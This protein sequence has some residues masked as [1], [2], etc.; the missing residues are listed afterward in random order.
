MKP[1]H[2]FLILCLLLF[3]Y[4]GYGQVKIGDPTGA[5]DP[6]AIL[7]LKDT[8]RG[9][10]LPR[11]TQ[12][13]M[14]AIPAPPDG[15]LIYNTSSN[16]IF[17]YSQPSLQWKPIMAD[18][19]EW[20]FDLSSAKLYLRRALNNEDSFYYNTSSRKFMF[21][22]TRIY[23]TSLGGS[24]NLDE[25]NSDRF[26]FKTT[27]SRF[28]RPAENL[29][30]ANIYSVYEVDNDT[31]AVSHPFEASYYGLSADA[32]VIPTA[33]QRIGILGGVRTFTTFNGADS[34]SLAMGV[35]SLVTLRGKNYI[36][37]VN[38]INNSVSIRD[39]VTKIGQVTG[40]QNTI[41]YVSPLGTPR[42]EGNLYGYF[43]SM[44]TA[45]NGKVDG[46]AYGI[47]LGNVNAAGVGSTRNFGIFT[48]KGS[49][50]FGDSVL[51][52]DGSGFRARTVL[53]INSTSAMIIPVG[54]SAQRPVTLYS[55]MLRYNTDNAAPE[56]FNGTSWI[57]LKNP[58]LASTGLI[59]PPLIPDNTT[60]PVNYTFT[61]AVSGNTVTIS[62]ASPLPSGIVIAW[63][64]VTTLNQVTIGFANFSGAPV[65][66]PAQTF[67]IKLVQ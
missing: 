16:S 51:I 38:G 19:S 40:I 25:G 45:L 23:R 27:A 29:N 64:T 54:T 9:F 22:D 32:T 30:S 7:E 53:D 49:N 48:N 31:I 3:T 12:S 20:F 11:M 61:G 47:F 39:S 44:S 4:S 50:R 34:L 33:T 60:V 52:T 43:S 6:G 55:G 17:Q 10:L 59:D 57:S 18:S 63:A 24:F 28:P 65:D 13:H 46:N 58:V 66:L 42:I 26:I 5:P 56:A 37:L 21:A 67:Y 8:T 14:N 36:E 35:Q 62:P 15:L 2:F 41:S 1:N